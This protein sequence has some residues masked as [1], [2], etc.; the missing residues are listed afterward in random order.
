[1]KSERPMSATVLPPIVQL[2]FGFGNLIF[3]RW[4]APKGL[5]GQSAMPSHFATDDIEMFARKAVFSTHGRAAVM[6]TVAAVALTAVEPAGSIT[7]VRII[8][9]D[10][11]MGARPTIGAIP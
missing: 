10:M 8:T 4:L 9:A 7:E 11:A 2:A 6:A 1:M 5:P 3:A